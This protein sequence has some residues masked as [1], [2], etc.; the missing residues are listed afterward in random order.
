VKVAYTWSHAIDNQ[1]EPLAGEFFDLSFTR[2]A[3]GISGLGRASFSRQFDSRGDGG[4]R[5]FDQ[6]HNLTF[7]AIWEIPAGCSEDGVWPHWGGPVGLPILG[8]GSSDSAFI[9]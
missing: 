4:V 9:V 3:G 2:A 8:D 5:D 1:S 7:T 6:T